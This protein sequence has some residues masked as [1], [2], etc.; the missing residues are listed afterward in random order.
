MNKP[1]Y[2]RPIALVYA[3]I[4]VAAIAIG[5]YLRSN[6]QAAPDFVTAEKGT[7]IQEVNVTGTLKAAETADLSFERSGKVAS[8]D[9]KIGDRVTRGQNLIELTNADLLA[10]LTQAEANVKSQAARVAELKR[11]TRPEEIQ[12]QENKVAAAE[13]SLTDA[14]RDLTDAIQDAYFKADDA[15][16]NK[17]DKFF[18]NPRSQRP[19]ITFQGV[20]LAIKADLEFNR[21]IIEQLLLSWKSLLDGINSDTNLTNILQT[22]KKNLGR[23]K[24]FVDTTAFAVNG[25][26]SSAGLSEETIESWKTDAAENRNNLNSATQNLS[27]AEEKTNDSTATLNIALSE[28]ALDKAG[29]TAESIMSAEADLVRTNAEAEAARV[30]I[31]KTVLRSP[32]DGIVTKQ[33]THLGEIVNQGQVIATVISGNKFK[34][35]ANVPE[36][37]VV[38]IAVG[39]SVQISFDALADETFAGKIISI[40]PAETVIEGVTNFKIKALLDKEDTRLKT[41]LTANLSI[42]SLKKENVIRLPRYAIIENDQ[43]TF[44]KK[45]VDGTIVETPVSLG[46]RG[47]DGETEIVSGVAEA[48][49]ILNIGS[50][51]KTQ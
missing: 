11:G 31:G 5:A 15:I 19:Q 40:D 46:L 28:L 35:E 13:I 24:T 42:E 25:L 21:L 32:I 12:I 34:I 17:I 14:R 22:S 9:V 6:K 10:Q 7:I 47:Q 36:V 18:T 23:I 30:E 16:R 20:G 3:L 50:K 48:D 51:T 38:K 33:D 45:V 26:T 39:N 1:L 41:G 27:G 43:G 44:V 2:K 4:M 49:K 8:I 37:D 29:A